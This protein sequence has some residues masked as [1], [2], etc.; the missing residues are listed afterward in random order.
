MIAVEPRTAGRGPFD[1]RPIAPV[2]L[3]AAVGAAIAV[4]NVG[5]V[6]AWITGPDFQR[7]PTGADDPPGWMQAVFSIGQIALPLL[8]L[9]VV[10]WF[11]VRPW[12]VERRVT[13]DGLM[14]IAALFVSIWDPVSSA[15]QPWF[16]YNS[17]LLNWG[18][19]LSSMPGWLS[20][21]EPGHSLAWSF[22]VLPAIYVIVLPLVGIIGSALIRRIRRA[23][24]RL[25]TPAVALLCF[26]A[27]IPIEI[28]FEGVVFLP[29][30]FWSY[31]GGWWPVTFGGHYYQL[32]LNE[33]IHVAGI[34]TVTSF[35]RAATNDRGET[36]VE[37]GLD[38][39]PRGAPR[40]IGVRLL[41]L[42]AAVH[43]TI[44]A[45]YHIPQMFWALNSPE[46]PQDVKSR[47]YF[48]NQCGPDVDR[49]CPGPDVPVIRPSSGY[50]DWEGNYVPGDGARP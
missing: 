26:G 19:P 34:F 29:L 25:R 49:A 3:L 12:R 37:R 6:I 18:T 24:P 36:V 45:C 47:S 21:N 11:L 20:L 4:L 22:P 31:A 28:V 1:V 44:F 35:L 39:L 38:H 27:M 43:I 40:H 8:A 10:Y 9:G 13:Y 46:W 32:P 50:V 30:G 7:V 23:F 48:M 42:I 41:A 33:L 14:C 2:Q 15:P 16:G 5:L 17:H